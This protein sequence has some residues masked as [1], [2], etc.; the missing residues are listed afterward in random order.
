MRFFRCQ[1]VPARLC[2]AAG[3]FMQSDGVEPHGAFHRLPMGEAAA[4]FH[5]RITVAAGHFDE[6][7][8]HAV[9]F[10]F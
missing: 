5:Q 4:R 7:A 1:R 8:E 10:D 9:V 6:I 3:F 2:N